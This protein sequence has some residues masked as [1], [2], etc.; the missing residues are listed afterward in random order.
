MENIF[1][2]SLIPILVIASIWDIF[3]D[4]KIPNAFIVVGMI[5]GFI[6]SFLHGGWENLLIS[7]I[8]FSVVIIIGVFIL[9]GIMAAGDVK[10][11]AV[12]SIF[13]GLGMTLKITFLSFFIGAVCFVV[14][15]W[16][17]FNS[18]LKMII[19]FIFYSVPIRVYSKK[20][21]VAFSPYIVIAYLILVFI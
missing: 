10:L 14:F 21:A 17:R 5:I 8:V 13:L 1:Y 19:N 16:K 2:F 6:Y 11:L 7:L 15:D 12:I 3:R 18:S 4:K 9:W 20:Q